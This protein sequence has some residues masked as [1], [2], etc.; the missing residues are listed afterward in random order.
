MVLNKA[1]KQLNARQGRLQIVT[2]DEFHQVKDHLGLLLERVAVLNDVAVLLRT[3][4]DHFEASGRLDSRNLPEEVSDVLKKSCFT[5]SA[6]AAKLREA[7]KVF[8]VQFFGGNLGTDLVED[9][10]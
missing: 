7:V 8:H 4:L 6:E 10:I 9:E 2:L 5:V 1:L 3:V